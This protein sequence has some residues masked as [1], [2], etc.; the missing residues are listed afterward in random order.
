MFI[1][2]NSLI[3]FT[4]DQPDGVLMESS[5]HL[6]SPGLF[7]PGRRGFLHA[8]GLAGASWLT[9]VGHLLAARAAKSREPAQSVILIW[10]KGGPSPLETL[11]PEPDKAITGGTK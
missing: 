5:T 1:D 9:P 7:L 8:L 6:H 10:L 2:V 4:S 3:P 11:D